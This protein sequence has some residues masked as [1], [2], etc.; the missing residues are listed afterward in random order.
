MH[1]VVV[2]V[3]VSSHTAI[4]GESLGSKKQF[5]KLLKRTRAE[6]VTHGTN[7][8]RLTHIIEDGSE[9]SWFMWWLSMLTT[10]IYSIYSTL[11][12]TSAEAGW[13]TTESVSALQTDGGGGGIMGLIT[14]LS[15]PFLW[16]GSTLLGS[17]VNSN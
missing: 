2:D 6:S 12:S 11:T 17:F 8:E 9:Q 3:L 16:L 7:G 4:R 10:P 13:E 15:S 5:T 1:V 14:L